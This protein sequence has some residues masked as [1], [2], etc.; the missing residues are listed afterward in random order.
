[1]LLWR[2]TTNKNPM[3]QKYKVVNSVPIQIWLEMQPGCKVPTN[4][5][6][7]P[8]LRYPHTEPIGVCPILVM[9]SCR[10]GSTRVSVAK[11]HKTPQQLKQC[12]S[13]STTNRAK[14]CHP[15]FCPDDIISCLEINPFMPS[16]TPKLYHPQ[17]FR[18]KQFIILIFKSLSTLCFCLLATRNT[19]LNDII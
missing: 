15:Y 18:I 4:K 1:M 2:K 11:T 14:C 13:S 7:P 16:Q 6:I 3:D 5:Q 8:V 19:F 12:V 9:P 10:Q 17:G